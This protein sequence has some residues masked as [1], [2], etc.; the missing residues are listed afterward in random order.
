MIEELAKYHKYLPVIP[1][2]KYTLDINQKVY[3]T[4]LV[5][6]IYFLMYHTSLIGLKTLS[7][8]ID[9][10]SIITASKIGTLVTL[11]ITPLI[12]ASLIL[13]FLVRGGVIKYNL[14]NQENLKRFQEAQVI[15][16][17]IIAV[18]QGL[19]VTFSLT[20]PNSISNNVAEPFRGNPLTFFLI[21]I[22]IIL[23]V[24]IIIYLDQISTKYGLLSGISLFIAAGVGYSVLSLFFY[25]LLNSSNGI[26]I[27][28]LNSSGLE[29]FQIALLQ[30]IPIITTIAAFYI[31]LY[32]NSFKLP[33][34]LSVMG[35]SRKIE[36]PFFYLSTIPII[37]SNSVLY[38]M[39]NLGIILMSTPGE[40]ILESILRYFGVIF[41]LIGPIPIDYN[42]YS[43]L[44]FV[45][46]S[47]V[48]II[49]I[50]QFFHI[51]TYIISMSILSTIFGILWAEAIGQ[52]GAA[53]AKAISSNP[54]ISLEGYRRDPRILEKKIQESIDGLII[55]GSFVIGFVAAL[56]DVFLVLGGSV[57][58]LLF[59]SI[60]EKVLP[61][62]KEYL[63]LNFPFFKKFLGETI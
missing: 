42:V 7:S 51:F 50:P 58:L 24:I 2:P 18:I 32:L 45:F 49:G 44:S 25:L 20:G 1:S 28:F 59:V 55:L 6:V 43:Y 14:D 21:L 62:I 63:I 16:A 23:G 15:F 8:T 60:V 41:Y 27:L 29:T 31:A 46:G 12:F 30:T 52:N 61:S 53:L 3:W 40:G 5:L 26:L 10:I 11:G 39:S 13:Q 36:I 38:L 4:I 19:I 9:L 54:Q 34:S 56:G 47:S 33:L 57:G 37:F 48:P 22:Q 35:Q 17:I